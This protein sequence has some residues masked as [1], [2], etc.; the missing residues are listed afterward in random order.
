MN[1]EN[2]LLV[3]PD[4]FETIDIQEYEKLSAIGYTPEQLALFYNIAKSA[5][6]HWFYVE[7]SI[8]MHHYNRGC[9]INQATEGMKMLESSNSGNVTQGQRLDKLRS[10][11]F[12]EQK[13]RELIYGEE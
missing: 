10:A 1:S 12:F 8:L 13:K 4:W 6:L 3:Q 5:F 7:N 11:V 9:L 2:N